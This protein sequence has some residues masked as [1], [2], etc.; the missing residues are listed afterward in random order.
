MVIQEFL[1]QNNVA[2]D[3]LEHCET[4]DAQRM[5]RAVHV[6]GHQVAKTV[7]LRVGEAAD[8]VVVVLP[9]SHNIDFD[10]AREALGVKRVELATEVEMS[11]RCPDCEM[12]ALPPFGSQYEMTTIVDESLT[13]D[14]K[15]VFEGCSHTEAIRMRYV[16]FARLENPK[17][18][19]ISR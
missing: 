18:V 8:Y 5:A 19:S 2:F 1:G 15:I 14:D 4:Y 7:L 13:K 10:K 12:G 9:A 3:V 17:V 6:S 11:Q 16:D